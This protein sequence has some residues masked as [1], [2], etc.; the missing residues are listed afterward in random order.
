LVQPLSKQLGKAVTRNALIREAVGEWL[1]RRR[2]RKLAGGDHE[3]RRIKPFEKDR[4]RL[5]RTTY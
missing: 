3:L 4:S 2:P 5:E 1:D